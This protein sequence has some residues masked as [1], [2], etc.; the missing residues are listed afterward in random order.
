MIEA[1]LFKDTIE[2]YW[3]DK[4]VR[5]AYMNN[6]VGCFHKN[7]ML[8]KKM[9]EKHP[10]KLEWFAKRERE[11]LGSSCIVNTRSFR[12]QQSFG[13][14]SPVRHISPEEYQQCIKY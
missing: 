9:W 5:F 6:C 12:G 13:A 1:G 8:L 4:P 11:R 14:A 3:R 2:E 7:P 10:N